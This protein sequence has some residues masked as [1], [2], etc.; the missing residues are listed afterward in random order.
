M[1]KFVG[2]RT[3]TYSYFI[4]D[5]S[6]DR[7]A[8]GT[9]KYVVKRKLKFENYQNCLEVTQLDNEIIYLK[10]LKLT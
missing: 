7:I 2:L 10:K 4:N 6:E 3:K 5:G 9:I 8:K 1:T